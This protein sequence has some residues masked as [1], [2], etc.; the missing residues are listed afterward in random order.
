MSKSSL[1]KV[2][3]VIFLR[4]GRDTLSQTSQY[5]RSMNLSSRRTSERAPRPD[6][7]YAAWNSFRKLP[8]VRKVHLAL[9]WK[10][11]SQT[12]PFLSAIQSWKEP[13]K[14]WPRH[15]H[16]IYR[17]HS[18]RGCAIPSLFYFCYVVT[19]WGKVPATS[20]PSQIIKMDRSSWRAGNE[21][22][23]HW[24]YENLPPSI[25]TTF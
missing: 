21:Q 22:H 7:R 16:P 24:H 5:Q 13:E 6:Q 1:I 25:W 3:H 8:E 19:I 14:H 20:F 18:G 9:C 23:I 4:K 2:V 10:G 17:N 15:F 11:R 12:W